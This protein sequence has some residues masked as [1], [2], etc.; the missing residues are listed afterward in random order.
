M[1]LDHIFFDLDGTLVDSS[2]G[3]HK[4]FV[5]AFKQL[6]KP[7]PSDDIIR[8]FMG[9]PLEVT[10]ENEVGLELA[11]DAVTLYREYYK[12]TGQFEVQLY[13]GIETLLQELRQDPDKKLY[14]TTSKNET[15]ALEMCQHLG[16]SHYFDGIYGSIPGALH[17][18]DVLKRA[19][20]ENGVDKKTAVIVG[21][22]KFD[23]I[24]GQT[25][26]IKTLAVN[27]GFGTKA[28]LEA[29]HPDFQ[30]ESPK[31]A[32]TILRG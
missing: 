31:E 14:I 23:M 12:A 7:I 2:E 26:G 5:K 22:T 16:I 20:L 11:P 9:P 6:G 18:A 8:S 4:G 13:E 24:G 21:D 3:I 25:V 29:E 17:K 30:V 27:W 10:F 1:T 19:L 28:S 32:L 15:I